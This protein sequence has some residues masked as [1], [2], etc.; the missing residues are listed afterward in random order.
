MNFW[1]CVETNSAGTHG[2]KRAPGDQFLPP[3]RQFSAQNFH[4]KQKKQPLSRKM[5]ER[6][7]ETKVRERRENSRLDE[8]IA[9]SFTSNLIICHFVLGFTK[10][11]LRL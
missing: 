9:Y 5:S 3:A 6:K 11:V 1:N 10:N 2:S 4:G 8:H 7:N